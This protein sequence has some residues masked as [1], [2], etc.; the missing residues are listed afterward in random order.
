MQGKEYTSKAKVAFAMQG[1]V[2]LE[3]FQVTEGVSPVHA[4]FSDK[5]RQGGHHLGFFVTADQREWMTKE[6]KKTGVPLFQAGV[7]PGRG[8]VHFMDAT[9]TGGIFFELVSVMAPPAK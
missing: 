4:L 2:Q 7:V 3:L 8:I 6:L 9:K 5:G 1:G